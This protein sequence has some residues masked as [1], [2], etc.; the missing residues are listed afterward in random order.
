[1]YFRSVK[2]YSESEIL[3][4]CNEFP[5]DCNFLNIRNPDIDIT[6]AYDN[7]RTRKKSKLFDKTFYGNIIV[8]PQCDDLK[9]DEEFNHFFNFIEINIKFFESKRNKIEE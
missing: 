7:D 4:E 3:C 2:I 6:V 8:F 1:M 5:N 9:E